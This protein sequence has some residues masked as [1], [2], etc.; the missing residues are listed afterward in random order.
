MNWVLFLEYGCHVLIKME[1][2]NTSLENLLSNPILETWRLDEKKGIY[3][4]RTMNRP[5]FEL[6]KNEKKG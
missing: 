2:S 1:I 3:W 4:N 5:F 6:I